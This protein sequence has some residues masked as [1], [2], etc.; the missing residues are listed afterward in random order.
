M[1]DKADG[2][3]LVQLAQWGTMLGLEDAM[4]ALW[5]DDFDPEA[6][7]ADDVFVTR[8]L[9]W[10]ETIGTLTKNG[11]FDTDLALD[12]LWVAGVWER[13]AP[14]ARKLREK[15]GAAEIYENFEALALRQTG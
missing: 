7:S 13:V 4:Q 9:N 14:A 8:V 3:L 11:L 1:A 5:S 10:G 12:W 6:A 15:H 2:A